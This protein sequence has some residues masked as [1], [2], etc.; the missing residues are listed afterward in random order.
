MWDETD[1]DG[2]D[3]EEWPESDEDSP[4]VPC[5]ECGGDVYEEADHCPSCGHFLLAAS[6]SPLL[7]KPAWFVLLGLLG[8][9][10]TLIV[11]SSGR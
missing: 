10:A 5:P 4:T 3:E 6:A 7:G 2:T 8:I 1:E 11:L 9:V